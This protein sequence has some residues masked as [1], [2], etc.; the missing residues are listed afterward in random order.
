MTRGDWTIG[1]ATAGA[2]GVVCYHAP[3]QQLWR[4]FTGDYQIPPR[5]SDDGTAAISGDPTIFSTPAEWT[6]EPTLPD[7]SLIR[8]LTQPTI[9]AAYL[10]QAGSGPRTFDANGSIDE[11][12]PDKGQALRLDNGGVYIVVDTEQGDYVHSMAARCFTGTIDSLMKQPTSG[13]YA[14]G[15]YDV[16][17]V[18]CCANKGESEH[19]QW[20]RFDGYLDE[21]RTTFRAVPVKSVGLIPFVRTNFVLSDT[22][23]ANNL[24]ACSQMLADVPIAIFEDLRP[25][26]DVPAFVPDWLAYWRAGQPAPV[27]IMPVPPVDSGNLAAKLLLR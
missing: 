11:R 18:Q 8:Q 15:A 13:D 12:M 3:T 22:D 14:P 20:L 24:I 25:V 19:D 9:F 7:K 17:L 2:P 23:I 16:M 26:A 21:L 10:H 27:Q 4:V 6:V 5:L 1:Q